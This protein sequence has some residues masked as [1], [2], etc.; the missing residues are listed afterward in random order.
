MAVIKAIKSK[1]L[2]VLSLAALIQS[3]GAQAGLSGF[4]LG[5]SYPIVQEWDYQSLDNV[6]GFQGE[7]YFHAPN[8]IASVFPQFHAQVVYNPFT[9]RALSGANLG[10]IGLA[11][12]PNVGL[13]AGFFGLQLAKGMQGS[14]ITPFFSFDV[15][16]AFNFMSFSGTTASTINAAPAFAAQVVPGLDVPIYKGLGVEL[17]VPM[18]FYFFRNF[19]MVLE[20]TL[21]LRIAL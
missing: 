11:S 18:R 4:S 3:S 14:E 17:E 8:A 9:F 6:L 19:L 2:W 15:G 16:G 7:L 21:A 12:T 1:A 13:V 10:T 5:A 20:P